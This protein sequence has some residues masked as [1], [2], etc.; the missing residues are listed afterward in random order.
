[1]T[2]LLNSSEIE[3]TKLIAGNYKIPVTL[4]H[5]SKRIFFDCKYNKILIDEFKSM[6]GSRWHGYDEEPLK[7]WSVPKTAR[8][9]FQISFLKGENP[10]KKFRN[11]DSVNHTSERHLYA[12]QQAMIDFVLSRHFALLA[13]EMGTG[14]TLAAIEIMEHTLPDCVW[15]VGPKSGV[16]AVSRELEK[17]HSKIVPEMYTYEAL[18]KKIT[19]WPAG[20]KAPQMVIFDECSKLKTPTSQRT[21]AAQHLA[22]SVRVDWP[23][24]GY[25]IG[26]SGTPA[27]KS[28]IDWWSQ[29]EV[30][31]PGFIK[32]GNIHKF[33]NRLCIIEERESVTGGIY[34]HLVTFLD[35]SD[36]C[37]ICG[38]F[39]EEHIAEH[40]FQESKNEVEFL[41]RRL[42]GLVLVQFKK[43]CLDLPEKIYEIINIKPTVEIL[44]AVNLIK[45]TSKRAIE[46]LSLIRE[47][48][49]GFQYKDIVSGHTDCPNCKGTGQVL[50]DETICVTCGGSGK[51]PVLTNV[52]EYVG[53]PK[54]ETFL[55]I[56]SEH[57]E[58]GRFIVWGGF[59]ATIDRL[60]ELCKKDG[61]HVL[62]VDGRGYKGYTPFGES[63]SSD[64]LLSAMDYSN[65]KYSEY[66]EKYPK[67]AFVGHPQAGGM[68]LTLTA[69]PIELFYSNCFDGTARM[70]SE[71]RFHR[72]GMDTNRGARI[73]DLI[74]LPTD[75]LVLNNLKEKKKL[76]SLT[77]GDLENCLK[78]VPNV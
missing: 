39:Q 27:P 2:E 70:Q 37:A 19:D 21:Q 45:K 62:Q 5:T 20:L 65:P 41:Y 9:L 12:H 60:T 34:P 26:M 11:P 71:D 14:K 52:T 17:W 4:Y 6:E 23:N 29:C 58:V 64:E 56:L 38:K 35:N 10:Y 42:S 8:N 76:Q 1:M 15:Y 28:P 61:W 31:C 25:I 50:E 75:L 40:D 13:C 7:M 44:R 57:E 22:D 33:R 63:C 48:S 24:Q 36:K 73:V 68:A 49:D 51:V 18:V 55:E 77:M 67:I 53:T 74:M 66:L 32:E 78:E 46:A 69:S 72:A 47:L 59:T 30:I 43:D 54:E 3:R 16:K